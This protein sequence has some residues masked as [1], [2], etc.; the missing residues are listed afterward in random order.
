[1][2]KTENVKKDRILD[3]DETYLVSKYASYDTKKDKDI[4]L[5][6]AKGTT[7]RFFSLFFSV[8]FPVKRGFFLTYPEKRRF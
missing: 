5:T 3:A 1:M 8:F 2:S 4:K 7:A 6:N